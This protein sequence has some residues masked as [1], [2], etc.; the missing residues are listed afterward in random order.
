MLSEI[1]FS[2]SLS[3]RVGVAVGSDRASFEC[4]SKGAPHFVKTPVM[5]FFSQDA[6]QNIIKNHTKGL[7]DMSDRSTHPHA[8]ASFVGL[9]GNLCEYFY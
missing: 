4:H 6:I 9:G 1:L 2:L 5:E 8:S 3:Y 7:E